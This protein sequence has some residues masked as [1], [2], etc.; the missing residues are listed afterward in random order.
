MVDVWEL[1]DFVVDVVECCMCLLVFY[2]VGY[3]DYIIFFVRKDS[4]V[5]DLIIFFRSFYILF[6]F[7][8][9][10]RMKV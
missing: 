4:F 10:T 9:E 6:F 3:R 7:L 2:V 5:V 8:F 1:L